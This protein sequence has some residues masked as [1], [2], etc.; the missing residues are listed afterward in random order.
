MMVFKNLKSL[1]HDAIQRN[2]HQNI[3]NFSVSS[4]YS[5]KWTKAFISG[6]WNLK[7]YIIMNIVF[8]TTF[9]YTLSTI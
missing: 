7:M 1:I 6:I 9:V 3:L 8:N 5:H 2:G 4:K